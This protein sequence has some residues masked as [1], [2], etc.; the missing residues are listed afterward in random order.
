M[1]IGWVVLGLASLGIGIAWTMGLLADRDRPPWW[2]SRPGRGRRRRGSGQDRRSSLGAGRARGRPRRARRWWCSQIDG[3]LGVVDLAG[4]AGVLATHPDGVAALLEVAGLI[5]DQHR[6]RVA[7]VLDYQGAHVVADG[8]VVPHRPGQQVLQAV[9]SSLA[10]VLGDRPAVLSGQVSQQPKHQR[11]G[12]APWLHP[13][14]PAGDPAHHLIEQLLPP[15][16]VNLYAVACG[17]RPI[18]G[19]VHNT[20]SSTVAALLR[21]PALPLTSQVT[22]SGWSIRTGP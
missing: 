8:A 12:V 5:D 2:R 3:D 9:G 17:H 21:S 4:G 22:N 16:R 1:D 14:E 11:P 6:A 15:G 20:G 10:S 18:F 7:E 13:G 19:C